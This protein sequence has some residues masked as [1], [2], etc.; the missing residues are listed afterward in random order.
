MPAWRIREKMWRV[1]D[2]LWAGWG[3]RLAWL[4]KG[5]DAGDEF[6]EIVVVEAAGLDGRRFKLTGEGCGNASLPDR[7]PDGCV[8]LHIGGFKAGA[9][10]AGTGADN[11]GAGFRE[12][13][14]ELAGTCRLI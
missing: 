3:P 1:E 14:V 4:I 5:E 6:V 9:Q 11:G 10:P 2:I 8:E 12:T 13:G 7:A